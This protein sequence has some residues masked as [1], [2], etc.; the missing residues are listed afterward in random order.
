[1]YKVRIRYNTK[2]IEGSDLHWRVLIDGKENLATFVKLSIPT[3]T[4]KELVDGVEKW[5]IACDANRIQWNGTECT[6]S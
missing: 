1:M 3:Y 6:I 2:V 4:T 5:H